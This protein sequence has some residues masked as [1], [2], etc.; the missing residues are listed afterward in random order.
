MLV[1]PACG[2]ALRK[3]DTVTCALARY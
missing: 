1:P 3:N 2:T